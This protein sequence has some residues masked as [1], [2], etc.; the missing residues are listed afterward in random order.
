MA[1]RYG[2][3]IDHGKCKIH[4]EP[5]VGWWGCSKSSRLRD[6]IEGDVYRHTT[7][8]EARRI[9][10]VGTGDMKR[11]EEQELR[12]VTRVCYSNGGD[13]NHWCDLG[14]FRQWMNHSKLIK[15]GKNVG[16]SGAQDGS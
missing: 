16:S 10:H 4:G 13:T 9:I 11:G 7:I 5:T 8:D 1:N 15:D 6:P 2:C 14:T 3:A 12:R